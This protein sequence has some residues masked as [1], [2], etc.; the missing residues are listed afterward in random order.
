MPG[1]Q[2][3]DCIRMGDAE[4]RLLY[5][6]LNRT[7]RAE[8][9]LGGNSKRQSERFVYYGHEIPFSI[10][11]NTTQQPHRF[12][13]LTR[14]LSATGISV[15]HGGF[16]YQD[17]EC[18]LMLRTVDGERVKI[19][20]TVV[21]CRLVKGRV[22]ELGVR[23]DD[24]I[25]PSCF[26]GDDAKGTE[27]DRPALSGA[28]LVLDPGG[29]ELPLLRGPLSDTA[30][31]LSAVLTPEECVEALGGLK[32]DVLVCPLDDGP[33][34]I[35]TCDIVRTVRDAGFTGPILASTSDITLAAVHKATGLGAAGVL[36]K[37]YVAAKLI[38]CFSEHLTTPP[39]PA[40]AAA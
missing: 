8:R 40:A 22:H 33:D 34:D 18:E 32:I 3:T 12:M 13:A 21:H 9:A 35:P 29:E 6:A 16:V 4:R 28:V 10:Y 23:F 37:P 36:R 26:V 15:L 25:D 7:E 30:L 14:N 1:N 19:P 20:G 5:D 2:F 24:Q 31:N 11:E 17:S 27:P 38:E 39:P